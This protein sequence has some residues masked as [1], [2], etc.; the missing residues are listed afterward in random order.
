MVLDE[1]EVDVV[2]FWLVVLELVM[3]FRWWVYGGVELKVG[4]L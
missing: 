4:G 2:D 1:G 3:V